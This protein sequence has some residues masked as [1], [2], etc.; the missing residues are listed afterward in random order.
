M[1]G[2][3][4][5]IGTWLRWMLRGD[6]GMASGGFCILL[7]GCEVRTVASRLQVLHCD[8]YISIMNEPSIFISVR[9]AEGQINLVSCGQRL[10]VRTP[11]SD[12]SIVRHIGPQSQAPSG[13]VR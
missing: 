4:N 8:G 2:W 7:L 10:S 5:G 1:T 9:S 6:E 13:I 11:L 12:C 3:L